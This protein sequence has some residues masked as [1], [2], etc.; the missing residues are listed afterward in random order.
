MLNTI[1]RADALIG[2]APT[3]D[4]KK[5][6]EKRCEDQKCDVRRHETHKKR[7]G[8]A[9]H[10]THPYYYKVLDISTDASHDE[11]K[12]AYHRRSMLYHP[13]TST[14]PDKRARYDN[15]ENTFKG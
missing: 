3:N 10:D 2:V 5:H 1:M 12:K 7:S 11:L 8:S 14:D 15:F 6:E 13:D 4:S 9:K